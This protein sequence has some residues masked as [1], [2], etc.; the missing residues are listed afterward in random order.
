MIAQVVDCTT[1]TTIH[2][3]SVLQSSI[4]PC[5]PVFHTCKNKLT[6]RVGCKGILWNPVLFSPRT[7]GKV[8]HSLCNFRFQPLLWNKQHLGGWEK[9]VQ[10]NKILK[11]KSMYSFS[12]K[13]KKS[14]RIEVQAL[15]NHY[16]NHHST[17]PCSFSNTPFSSISSKCRTS[18]A[19]KWSQQQNFWDAFLYICCQ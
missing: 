12:I 13:R 9:K 10:W 1:Y 14:G 18:V 11:W 17:H 3:N 8:Y 6:E 16:L 5:A 19:G 4:G 7:W 2:S 15:G